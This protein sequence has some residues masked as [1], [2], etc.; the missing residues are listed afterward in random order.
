MSRA[1][2]TGVPFAGKWWR[3]SDVKKFSM[4][5]EEVVGMCGERMLCNSL[6]SAT[7]F[8]GK[9][10]QRH[11]GTAHRRRVPL[12]SRR[13]SARRTGG[14][15]PRSTAGRCPGAQRAAAPERPAMAMAV[16]AEPLSDTVITQA[17]TITAT[18]T[19]ESSQSVRASSPSPRPPPARLCGSAAT[20]SPPCPT[21]VRSVVLRRRYL[22]GRHH[23][24]RRRR[25]P[26]AVAHQPHQRERPHDDLR[27]HQQDRHG[28][29]APQDL[30]SAVRIGQIGFVGLVTRRP[31][32]V[33]HRDGAHNRGHR[34]HRCGE[35]EGHRD[36]VAFRETRN[37]QGT[38]SDSQ[39][40]RGLPN[41]H[42]Q[43]ALLRRKPSDHESAAGR[44]AAGRRH[45]AEQQKGA[46]RDERLHR[47]RCERR[48]RRQRR[49]Q[50][51]HDPLADRSTM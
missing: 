1:R 18:L 20:A 17:I 49:T 8:D 31:W 35:Q 27:N 36:A 19:G 50:C 15:T 2:S 28:V 14:A 7:L 43:A 16:N 45:A 37:H 40:L 11:Q 30:R 6:R 9:R 22:G 5:S 12:R 42:H 10:R 21:S 41:A 38:Q 34:A 32:W 44:V 26:A 51:Q 23:R 48:S 29:D 25:G 4:R 46:D 47:C 3:H 24:T 33:D 13:R 39:R